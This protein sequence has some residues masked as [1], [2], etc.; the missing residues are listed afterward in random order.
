MATK[1]RNKPLQI[2]DLVKILEGTHDPSMPAH[3]TGLIVEVVESGDQHRDRLPNVLYRIQF[4]PSILKF[5]PMW[6]EKIS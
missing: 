6:V 2:G 5:H 1:T 4:G 3:R